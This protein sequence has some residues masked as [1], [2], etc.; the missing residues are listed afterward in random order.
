MVGFV[1]P[2]RLVGVSQIV[3]MYNISVSTFGYLVGF[4]GFVANFVVFVGCV[5]FRGFRWFCRFPLFGSFCFFYRS[6]SSIMSA[7]W[8][9]SMPS[10]F[11]VLLSPHL[12]RRLIDGFRRFDQW[13]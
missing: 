2:S 5:C 4:V 13:L 7:S 9:C 10:A 12:L 11:G 8:I 3:G 6:T 1:D